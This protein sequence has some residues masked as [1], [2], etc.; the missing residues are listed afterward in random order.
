VRA[1]ELGAQGNYSGESPPGVAAGSKEIFVKRFGKHAGRKH[2]ALFLALGV[3]AVVALVGSASG[4]PTVIHVGNLQIT[5][6]GSFSP[7]ALPKSKPAGITL[8]LEASIK[9]LDGTHVP[10]LK[11]VSLQFDKNGS[12]FTKGLPTCKYG[13][14]T[15]TLTAA[16]KAAC[17]KALVGTGKVTA[18]LQFPGGSKQPA[19]G[20]LLI[21]NGAPQGGK[22]VL[23]QH[24]YINSP[25]STTVVTKAVIGKAHGKYGTSTSID[26]PPL[27]GGYASL[28]SFTAKIAKSW[29]YKGKKVSLLNLKC[30]SGHVFAHGDFT[31]V[32]GTALH[33]DVVKTCT[34]KG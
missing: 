12:V 14:L 31:F 7:K 29:H 21:F 32:D 15:N 20:T 24:A 19:K 27:A 28:T 16:A 23:L 6:D 2:L 4:A 13:Q 33:G 3:A 1:Q 18:E 26:I 17:G 25:V 5:A 11:N 30:P 34:P 9:T 22:P 10:A 8:N